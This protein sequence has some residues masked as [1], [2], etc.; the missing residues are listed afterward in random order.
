MS[1][2]E[3]VIPVHTYSI[4]ARDPQT[5]ELGVA[6]QSHAFSV[7]SIVSWA[8]AGVGA[9]ATQSY[10]RLDYGPEGL[11]LMR[12]GLTASQALESLVQNDPDREV[13]QVAMVDAQGHSAVHTG[14]KCIAAAGHIAGENF[15]IQANLMID[16]S[17]VPAMQVAFEATHGEELVERLIATLEAAQAV[18][19]DIRGQQSAALLVVSGERHEKPWLGRIYDLRVEDHPHPV[20]ELRRLY[21]FRK[22]S[23]ML[24]EAE[25]LFE[26]QQLDE[27]QS[28]V[29]EALSLVPDF[30]E[31]RFWLAVALFTAGQEAEAKRYFHQVFEK[32]SIWR[33][34]LRRLVAA[35]RFPDD[36]AIL[37][38]ILEDSGE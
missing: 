34:I 22:A 28:V 36:P 37:K 1:S 35:G 17:V 15:S 7:G 9:V 29:D 38:Q 32:E 4:V 23:L 3:S 16:A 13:R 5:G 10:S 20:E 2:I 14:Q 24:D 11:A 18:G 33:D 8:E 6:V 26:A 21:H 12:I 30:V 25:K 19:G 27:A 31:F